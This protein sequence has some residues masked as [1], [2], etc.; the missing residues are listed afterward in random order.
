M[1]VLLTCGPTWV[2]IDSVRIISNR[3]TGQMGA[4]IVR[5]LKKS[6]ALVTEIKGPLFFDDFKT[7]LKR[8]LRKKYDVVI[9]AA[10]VS[11]FKAAAGG[12]GKLDSTKALTL[13]LVP[14]EKLINSIK[15]ISPGS[16]LV[17]FKL[18]PDLNARNIFSKTRGLFAQSGCDL[19]VAN[20]LK[21]G[22]KGFIVDA[23][24]KVLA[25]ANNKQA[26]ANDLVKLIL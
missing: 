5:E 3:S 21:R 8:E 2:P 9:H 20:T 10:A 1:R 16:F 14:T 11:D 18:E 7:A 15:K 17:G 12:K 24:G 19:V 22:Y 23:D 4:L 13:R 6:G 25:Q 26:I